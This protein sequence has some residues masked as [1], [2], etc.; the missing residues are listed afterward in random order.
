MGDAC[1]SFRSKSHNNAH[2]FFL[3]DTKIDVGK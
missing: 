2:T 1:A 3:L